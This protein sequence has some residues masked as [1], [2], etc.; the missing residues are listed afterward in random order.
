LPNTCLI[1]SLS[2]PVGSL[3]LLSQWTDIEPAV[4]SEV[5]RAISASLSIEED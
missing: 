4:N 2:A 5:L 3:V 1:R